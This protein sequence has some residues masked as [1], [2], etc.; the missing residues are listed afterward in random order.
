MTTYTFNFL[1][2]SGSLASTA[3]FASDQDAIDHGLSI[4]EGR[5][6][7]IRIGF[8]ACAWIQGLRMDRRRTRPPTLLEGSGREAASRSTP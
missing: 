8:K 2:G 4:Y 7:D 3:D 6:L 1:T 5:N